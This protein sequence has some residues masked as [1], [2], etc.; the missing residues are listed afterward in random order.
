M[1]VEASAL[2]HYSLAELLAQML[3]EV[4]RVPGW[5]EMPAVG[6]ETF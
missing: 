5:E 2:P 4:P 1:T 6:R 3:D